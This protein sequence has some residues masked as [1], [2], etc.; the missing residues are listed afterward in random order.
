MLLNP[1]S[2][3]TSLPTNYVTPTSLPTVNIIPLK[4]PCYTFMIISSMQYDHNNYRVCV[5][6][7][8]LLLLTPLTIASWFGIYGSVLN[9][10]KSYLSSR[11]YRV[12]FNNTFFSFYTSCC[13]VPQGSVLG[14]LLFIMYTTPSALSSPSF[15]FTI[16]F[17]HTTPNCSRHFTRPTSTQAS[18]TCKITL[19][20]ISSW[21]IASLLTLNSSKTEFLLIGL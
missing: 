3:I 18:P 2:Q 13:G 14:P 17:M 16:T 10:F 11:S 9:W 20:Q 7:T 5:S 8:F 6:L 21:M 1:A 19:H 15:P 4:Q 12:R